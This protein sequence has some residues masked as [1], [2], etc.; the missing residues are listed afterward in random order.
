MTRNIQDLTFG[1]LLLI[2][3]SAILFNLSVG[4]PK[5][6]FF[7]SGYLVTQGLYLILQET[8]VDDND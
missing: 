4:V 8:E 5:W 3:G 2:L 7:F 6:V 1:C